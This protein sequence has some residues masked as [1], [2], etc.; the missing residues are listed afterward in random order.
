VIKLRL[1]NARDLDALLQAE[2]YK[3]QIGQ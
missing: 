2:A 3:K 1:E